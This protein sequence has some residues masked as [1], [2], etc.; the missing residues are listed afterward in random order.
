MNSVPGVPNN[1]IIFFYHIYDEIKDRH[2][3]YYLT[4]D[5]SKREVKLEEIDYNEKKTEN[6]K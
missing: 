1:E 5:H 2:D 6:K 3:K 4:V